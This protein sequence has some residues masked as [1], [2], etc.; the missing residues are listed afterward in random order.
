MKRAGKGRE[1]MKIGE[2]RERAFIRGL[3]P[4]GMPER[5]P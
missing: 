2:R 5:A 4:G 1:T 3:P